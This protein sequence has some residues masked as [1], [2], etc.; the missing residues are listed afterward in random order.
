VFGGSE[1]DLLILCARTEI[2]SQDVQRVK[3][4]VAGSLDWDS[5]LQESAHHGM[6]PLLYWNLS[7]IPALG[8]PKTV[9]NRLKDAFTAIA[10]RN[11]ALTRELVTLVNLLADSGV[12]ALP[13][14]GPLLAAAAY[15]NVS[16]RHFSDIDILVAKKDVPKAKEVLIKN[17]Y[18]P[19]LNLTPREERNYFQSHHEYRFIRS[20]DG[21]VIEIQ[22]ALCEET[23]SFPFVFDEY[24]DSREP[25]TL[26]GGEVSTFAPED[27]L[28]V[29]CVHGSQHRWRQLKWVCDINEFVKIY[30][31]KLNWK[32]VLHKAQVSGGERMLLLGLCVA[33]NLL[34]ATLPEEVLKKIHKER[35]IQSVGREVQENMFR[36]ISPHARFQDEPFVFFWR[37]KKRWRDKAA[38]VVKYFPEYFARMIKPNRKDRQ[39]L[40]LPSHLYLGYYLVRPVR[41]LCQIVYKGAL[42]VGRR[43]FINYKYR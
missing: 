28:L 21:I 39:F 19:R 7:R 26:A 43:R 3:G 2:P 17:S 37:T 31:E 40:S 41:L 36:G 25:M 23:F 11:L 14:K 9:L 16:L 34:D 38:L 18:R 27:L 29:L 22:W 12:R 1:A 5:L 4:I 6:I 35:V 32:R 42:S 33:R 24:W 20:A 8:L 10:W 30:G 13:Y 15:K